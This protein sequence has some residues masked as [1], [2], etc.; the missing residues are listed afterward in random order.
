MGRQNKLRGGN[1]RGMSRDLMNAEKAEEMK[2]TFADL[3]END[4]NQ[5]I[6][7]LTSILKQNYNKESIQKKV[8]KPQSKAYNQIL[9]QNVAAENLTRPKEEIFTP[10][11]N[12]SSQDIKKKF[13]EVQNFLTQAQA[14]QEN[15]AFYKDQNRK[16][17]AAVEILGKA[18]TPYFLENEHKK[19][20][21]YTKYWDLIANIYVSKKGEF[22]EN[23]LR[24]IYDALIGT[25]ANLNRAKS[26]YEAMKGRGVKLEGFNTV[27]VG[28]DNVS[29]IY[30]ISKEGTGY[31]ELT[32]GHY[33]LYK[34]IITQHKEQVWWIVHNKTNLKVAELSVDLSEI[35]EKTERKQTTFEGWMNFRSKNKEKI[36]G[37]KATVWYYFK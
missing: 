14:K 11:Q 18:L 6:G 24:S 9:Q 35:E 5:I 30:K 32:N 10:K 22:R 36:K 2:T 20:V 12:L 31:N 7:I 4:L 19:I 3:S 37:A 16:V 27:N 29:G 13:E 26:F 33:T 17:F 25:L 21:T 28:N 1:R 23:D 15:N 34:Q 8:V